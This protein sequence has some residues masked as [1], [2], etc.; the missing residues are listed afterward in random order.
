MIIWVRF[1]TTESIAKQLKMQMLKNFIIMF[2]LIITSVNGVVVSTS[3]Y[4][5]CDA[6]K[7]QLH[8]EFSTRSLVKCLWSCNVNWPAC[9]AGR[10]NADTGQCQHLNST[11][12][13]LPVT[14]STDG[15]WTVFQKVFVFLCT[16]TLGLYV[17]SIKNYNNRIRTRLTIRFD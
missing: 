17:H 8:D 2:L 10:Y 7:G 3:Y 14:W 11:T 5:Q 13:A 12:T 6:Y 1:L 15:Q 4:K 16:V 9:Q